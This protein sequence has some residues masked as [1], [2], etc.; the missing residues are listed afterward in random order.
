MGESQNDSWVSPKRRAVGGKKGNPWVWGKEM[1]KN[2]HKNLL[3]NAKLDKRLRMCTRRSIM[4]KLAS[5][6][7]T[8]QSYMG[9][10]QMLLKNE[11]D[12]GC[13]AREKPS[14]AIAQEWENIHQKDNTS[15][16]SKETNATK[17]H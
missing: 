17:K 15:R 7:Y 3:R 12:R 1:K 8:A 10:G 5:T 6:D 9:T 16:P 13:W 14:K 2:N 4:D 11:L